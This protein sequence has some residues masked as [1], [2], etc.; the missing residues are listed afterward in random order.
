V[1]S[2]QGAVHIEYWFETDDDRTDIRRVRLEEPPRI[3]KAT[4]TVEAPAYAR[5]IAGV[6]GFV[7]GDFELGAGDD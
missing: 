3:V 5:E 7:E 6:A 4:A 1:A 2:G